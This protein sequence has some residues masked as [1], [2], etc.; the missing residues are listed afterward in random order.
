MGKFVNYMGNFLANL[1]VSFPE[2]MSCARELEKA[3]EIYKAAVEKANLAA[4]ELGSK[5]EGS[6]RDAFMAEQA[7]VMKY[8]TWIEDYA[9]EIIDEIAKSA[10]QYQ[11]TEKKVNEIINSK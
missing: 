1:L 3:M 8:H 5:W 10:R 4:E 9:L 2:L 11:E 7:K 6:A